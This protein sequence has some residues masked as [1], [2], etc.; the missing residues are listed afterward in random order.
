MQEALDRASKGRTTLVVSHRLSAIRHAEHI[1]FIDKGKVVEEGSHEELMQL[2]GSYQKMVAAHEYEGNI[3]ELLEEPEM[4]AETPDLEKKRKASDFEPRFSE[5]SINS[6]IIKNVANA[7]AIADA[8]A[9]E[10]ERLKETKYI[11]TFFRVLKSARPEWGFLIVG[12]ICAAIYGCTQPAFSIILSEFFAAMADP[13]PEMV[14]KKTSVVSIISTAIGVLVGVV[15][16]TQI[17]FF[18]LSGVW[19]TTRMR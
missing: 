4:E 13:T 5:V 7:K 9:E 18:N 14:L 16:F 1:V 3:E 11:K 12:A 6:S 19:L 17:Y 8:D 2:G 15:C 10:K